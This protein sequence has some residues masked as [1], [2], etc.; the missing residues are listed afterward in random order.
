MV[1]TCAHIASVIWYL[2]FARYSRVN[3]ELSKNWLDSVNVAAIN[4]EVADESGSESEATEEFIF[5]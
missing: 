5:T 3:I 1:G 2:S 4:H